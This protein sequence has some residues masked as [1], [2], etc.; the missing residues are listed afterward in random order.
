MVDVCVG[1]CADGRCQCVPYG[2]PRAAAPRSRRA[3]WPRRGDPG[4]VADRYLPRGR[5]DRHLAH[6]AGRDAHVRAGRRRPLCRLRSRPQPV[7]RGFL[8]AGVGMWTFPIFFTVSIQLAEEFAPSGLQ[9]SVISLNH[10]ARQLGATLVL[11]GSFAPLAAFGYPTTYALVASALALFAA[12][13]GAL[14]LLCPGSFG[15]SDG[16]VSR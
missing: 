15:S 10:T 2:V 3:A 5:P 4:S 8:R 11:F 13:C 9:A 14:T 7:A 6:A 12:A 16:R 1:R